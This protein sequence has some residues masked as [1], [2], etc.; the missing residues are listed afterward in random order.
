[1]DDLDAGQARRQR[2]AAVAGLARGFGRGGRGRDRDRRIA[3]EQELIGVALLALGTEP[4]P[5]EDLEMT[6]H[7]R[8]LEV[9]FADHA[10]GVGQV[11]GKRRRLVT[12]AET[13]HHR[14]GRSRRDRTNSQPGVQT[15][16]AT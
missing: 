15:P 4:L 1:M 10:M 8:K 7:G 16:A 5:Q 12:H 2:L 6:L 14:I 13:I 3:E 9:Q 11:V